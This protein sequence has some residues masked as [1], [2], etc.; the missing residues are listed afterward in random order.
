LGALAIYNVANLFVGGYDLPWEK[1]YARHPSRFQ[2]PL[3]IIIEASNG[4][5]DYGNKF[6]VPLTTG[7]CT[8]FE[9]MCGATITGG[10]RRAWWRE[11]GV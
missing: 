5:S 8:S 6:G 10:E 11:T 9:L 7:S 2:R 3:E 1:E 4:A